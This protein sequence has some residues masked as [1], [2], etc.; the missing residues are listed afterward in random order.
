MHYSCEFQV[1]HV[2]YLLASCSSPIKNRRKKCQVY[3]TCK[4]YHSFDRLLKKQVSNLGE[5]DTVPEEHE[6]SLSDAN[7]E[8]INRQ[9]L[10]KQGMEMKLLKEQ[11][12]KARKD[13]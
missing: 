4:W 9:E 8:S 6:L 5:T 2:V 7:L 10:T 3:G 11:L 12:E 1:T 13:G